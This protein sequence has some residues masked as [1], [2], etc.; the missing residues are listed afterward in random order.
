MTKLYPLQV[1]PANNLFFFWSV[2]NTFFT[3]G[4]PAIATRA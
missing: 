3:F 4:N 2:L 1:K